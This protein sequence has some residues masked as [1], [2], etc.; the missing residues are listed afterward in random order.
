M[1]LMGNDLQP[2]KKAGAE[3]TGHTVN[4]LSNSTELLL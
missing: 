1:G 4:S 2:P 3:R